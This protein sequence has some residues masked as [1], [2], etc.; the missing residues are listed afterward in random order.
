MS[1]LVMGRKNTLNGLGFGLGRCRLQC[2][3]RFNV[4]CDST[5]WPNIKVSKDSNP[6]TV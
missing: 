5:S 2:L 4:T 6:N 3:S 1:S